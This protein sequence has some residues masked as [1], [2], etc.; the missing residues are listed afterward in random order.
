MLARAAVFLAFSILPGLRGVVGDVVDE[1]WIGMD[2]GVVVVTVVIGGMVVSLLGG[3]GDSRHPD[4]W[5][6]GI[7]APGQA[8]VVLVGGR[9]SSGVVVA[10]G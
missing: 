6:W 8:G 1:A 3:S 2:R 10:W 4:S 7:L 9:V 5:G